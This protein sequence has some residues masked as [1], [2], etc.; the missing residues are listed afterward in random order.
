MTS[1][2]EILYLAFQQDLHWY[3][4]STALLMGAA[5]LAGYLIGHENGFILA[6]EGDGI[7][8]SYNTLQRYLNVTSDENELLREELAHYRSITNGCEKNG[9]PAW[10]HH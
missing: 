2:Q 5:Y 8:M 1:L 7:G 9:G 10:P 3:V 6:E 4:I